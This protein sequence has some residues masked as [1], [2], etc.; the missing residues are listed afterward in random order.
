MATPGCVELDEDI[1]LVVHDDVFVVL[2]DDNGDG[3]VVVLGDRVGLDAGL[4]L[5][6]DKVI[7]EFGNVLGRELLVL[8]VGVLLVVSRVLDGK[9]GPLLLEVQVSGVLA[10]R[11][12]INGGKVELA[13]VLCSQVCELGSI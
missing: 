9:G 8:R 5:S 4:E 7:D 3:A 6:G 1:L 2:R 10:E 11:G 12:G 13:L